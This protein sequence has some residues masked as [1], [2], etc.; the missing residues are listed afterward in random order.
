MDKWWKW[1]LKMGSAAFIWPRE[2]TRL[3]RGCGRCKDTMGIWEDGEDWQSEEVGGCRSGTFLKLA[4]GSKLIHL[5]QGGSEKL[6]KSSAYPPWK[7]GEGGEDS[8]LLRLSRRKAAI[9]QQTIK[10]V[11]MP[12]LAKISNR[13]SRQCESNRSLVCANHLLVRCG[14]LIAN[15]WIRDFKF[16]CNTCRSLEECTKNNRS[17]K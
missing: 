12:L 8:R 15:K 1:P 14:E 7:W 9:L 11:K 16:F 4:I 5:L 6:F 10:K 13:S 17:V 2:K 3:R